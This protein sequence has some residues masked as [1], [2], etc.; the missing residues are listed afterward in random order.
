MEL[1]IKYKQSS[2]I[3]LTVLFDKNL[4]SFLNEIKKMNEISISK[5]LNKEIAGPIII[6]AGMKE[7]KT[8]K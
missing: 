8:R 3:S 5:I 2:K 6:D 1:K 7:N 4:K